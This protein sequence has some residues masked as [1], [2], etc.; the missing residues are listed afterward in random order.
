MSSLDIIVDQTQRCSPTSTFATARLKVRDG[1]RE[2]STRGVD[3]LLAAGFGYSLVGL[4]V[5]ASAA[6]TL[7]LVAHP[8]GKMWCAWMQDFLGAEFNRIR[9]RVRVHS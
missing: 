9:C 4:T 6:A 7:V 2:S 1:G 3:D 5:F 8:T